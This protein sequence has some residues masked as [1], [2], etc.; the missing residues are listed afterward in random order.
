MGSHTR[1]ESSTTEPLRYSGGLLTENQKGIKG[2]SRN[3]VLRTHHL[4]SGSRDIWQRY[5]KKI[6]DQEEV[7]KKESLLSSFTVLIDFKLFGI[8][9]EFWISVLRKFSIDVTLSFSYEDSPS[10]TVIMLRVNK[11]LLQPNFSVLCFILCFVLCFFFAFVIC[12]C[13][14]ERSMQKQ[15][16]SFLIFKL[17]K[18]I[19]YLFNTKVAMS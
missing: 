8:L 9:K 2:G 17:I 15:K 7:R 5:C 4:T 6:E 13:V 11:W 16:L 1:E 10:V 19:S 14:L 3:K 12:V 18:K